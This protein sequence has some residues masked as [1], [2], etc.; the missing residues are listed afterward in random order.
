MYVVLASSALKEFPP[1]FSK[2][3][4]CQFFLPLHVVMPGC[5]AY[6]CRNRSGEEKKLFSIPR[7]SQDQARRTEWLRRINRANFNP[8]RR[9]V[10]CEDHFT[11]DQFEPLVLERYGVKK[12]RRDA[13]PTI[14]C[15]DKS[16]KTS[17]VKV[18]A[19]KRIRTTK[20]SCFYRPRLKK[21]APLETLQESQ[22]QPGESV[23]HI[24]V[25]DGVLQLQ[26]AHAA[27]ESSSKDWLSSSSNQ[28][29]APTGCQQAARPDKTQLVQGKNVAAVSL[30]NEDCAGVEMGDRQGVAGKTGACS[31]SLVHVTTVC[32]STAN[33]RQTAGAVES[34]SFPAWPSENTERA[35]AVGGHDH[36]AKPVTPG[37]GAP[38]VFVTCLIPAGIENG[39]HQKGRD[40]C[41]SSFALC[42]SSACSD[43]QSEPQHDTGQEDAP[44]RLPLP[45]GNDTVQGRESAAEYRSKGH[46][47]GS[48]HHC[49][50]SETHPPETS[51]SRRYSEGLGIHWCGDCKL[52]REQDSADTSGGRSQC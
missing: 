7:S 35:T 8:S 51:F 12:L 16:A 25:D 18:L 2:L 11:D 38:E 1:H 10:L 32:S 49:C 21:K 15:Y 36:E 22:S 41:A 37:G 14:F 31:S 45:S 33:G 24:N 3:V 39:T 43:V 27:V 9:S 19:K 46:S 26:E 6:G 48:K 5:C 34:Y 50:W 4:L 52:A 30:P 42:Q 44:A 40:E 29:L 13:V 20:N 17:S 28:S 47:G 23:V